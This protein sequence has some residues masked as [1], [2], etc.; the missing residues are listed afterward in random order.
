MEL[1]NLDERPLS[2]EQDQQLQVFADHWQQLLRKATP[3]EFKDGQV[4]FHKDHMPYGVYVLVQGEVCLA[5]EES[6]KN[7]KGM[8]VPN[9]PVGI[10]LLLKN[11][12][13]PYTAVAKSDC[14]GFFIPK[15][16]ILGLFR[17]NQSQSFH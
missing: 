9:V 4:V 12:S 14:K 8:I 3:V 17:E 11:M 13:Y 6:A 10:D 16:D 2:E 5:K 7:H 1:M 15:K